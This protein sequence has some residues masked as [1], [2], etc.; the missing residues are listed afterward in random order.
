MLI[1]IICIYF[2]KILKY[3][4][5]IGKKK[6]FALFISGAK[7]HFP[8]EI[9][10]RTKQQKG[11]H[12]TRNSFKNVAAIFKSE[13]L[14]QI[15]STNEQSDPYETRISRICHD[16]GKNEIGIGGLNFEKSITTKAEVFRQQK[17]LTVF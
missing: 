4:Q 3:K 17:V 15:L 16:L 12:A 2:E 5:Y 7:Y 10:Q 8:S 1:L 13:K 9:R 14:S 11:S 6:N